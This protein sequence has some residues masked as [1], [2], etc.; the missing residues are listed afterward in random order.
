[1]VLILTD[2]F[3]YWNCDVISNSTGTIR[4]SCDVSHEILI[5]LTCMHKCTNPKLITYG[6]SP[7]TVGGLDPGM[8]YSVMIN[9]FDGSHVVLRD[10]MIVQNITVM[11]KTSNKYMYYV[12]NFHIQLLT[13]YVYGT[14]KLYCLI[15]SGV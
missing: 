9:V 13:S 5:T 1:M 3:H 4:V 11:N 15:Y 10:Q 8:M 2:T 6:N 14:G 12:Y 7:L